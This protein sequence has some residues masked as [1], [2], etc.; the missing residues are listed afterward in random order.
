MDEKTTRA[1][2]FGGLADRLD[3]IRQVLQ[4]VQAK[5]RVKRSFRKFFKL[6]GNS[7]LDPVVAEHFLRKSDSKFGNFK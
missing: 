1:Q 4:N 6:I 3:G 2:K 5:D 7:D